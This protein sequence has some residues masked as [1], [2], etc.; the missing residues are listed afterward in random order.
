MNASTITTSVPAQVCQSQA[1]ERKVK[2]SA[3]HNAA[4]AAKKQDYDEASM[5][6]S[7]NTKLESLMTLETKVDN[8][9]KL[10]QLFSDK[11]HEVL[12]HLWDYGKRKSDLNKR[13]QTIEKRDS[14]W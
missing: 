14:E 2:L 10:I 8:I 1:S 6:S 7:I 13:A 3:K 9:E 12:V 4:K 11:Y 5:L